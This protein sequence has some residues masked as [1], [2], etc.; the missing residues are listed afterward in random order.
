MLKKSIVNT[1]V[2]IAMLL[3]VFFSY[4]TTW[5]AGCSGTG[6]NSKDPGTTGCASGSYTVGTANVNYN[7]TTGLVELRWSPTCKTNW[8]KVKLNRYASI[9]L[10]L[11]DSVGNIIH[12]SNLMTYNIQA[13]GNM[14][15]APTALVKACA[16]ISY[17]TE[18]CT[19]LR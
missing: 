5:A 11:R 8:P 9:Q 10:V 18:F 12:D 7:G 3:T 4:Q 6:C 19:P 1:A 16:I 15:Y 13:Y 14:W 2:S 17:R